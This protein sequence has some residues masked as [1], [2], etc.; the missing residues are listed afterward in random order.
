[1]QCFVVRAQLPTHT[2]QGI[3]TSLCAGGRSGLTE[4][5]PYLSLGQKDCLGRPSR[6]IQSGE[7][8]VGEGR[9]AGVALPWPT[10]KERPPCTPRPALWA[11]GWGPERERALLF[12]T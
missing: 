2:S 10:G 11:A 9:R 7:G 3:S 8:E 1:M 12:C 6:V 4:A 5:P